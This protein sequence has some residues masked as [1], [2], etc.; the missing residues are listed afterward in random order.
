MDSFPTIG[1]LDLQGDV[2]EHQRAL[3]ACGAT[4]LLVKTIED[5]KKVDA[6]VIP[7]GE[8]TTIGKLME[9]YELA[10][11]IRQRV[12][13]GMPIYGTCAGAILLA[14]EIVGSE[15]AKTLGLMDISIERN[16]YGRQLE[17]FEGEVE[18]L[19][20]FFDSLSLS[21]KGSS[22]NDALSARGGSQSSPTDVD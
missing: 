22:R 17:S 3:K 2:I 1:I 6:L 13:E 11:P 7:G 18:F 5:L 8:S 21:A 10:E 9:W 4:V 12:A 20:P 14:Q 16:S 15:K 19:P